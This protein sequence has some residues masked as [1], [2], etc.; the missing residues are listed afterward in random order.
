MFL[1]L[2][3]LVVTIVIYLLYLNYKAIHAFYLSLKINGPSALPIIGN[4]L[5]FLN[6]TS[7]GTHVYLDLKTEISFDILQKIS[8]AIS[9]S[10]I[11]NFHRPQKTSTQ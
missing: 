6:N 2:S 10:S 5:L 3:V 8:C 9:N 1:I 11:F 4:G 7:A